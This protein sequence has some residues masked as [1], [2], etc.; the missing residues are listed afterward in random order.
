MLL[1][2]LPYKL[3]RLHWTHAQ[4]SP[5]V[6]VVVVVVVAMCVDV[7]WVQDLTDT[8]QRISSERVFVWLPQTAILCVPYNYYSSVLSTGT[9][10]ATCVKS[11]SGKRRQIVHT[12]VCVLEFSVIWIALFTVWFMLIPCLLLYFLS[13]KINDIHI[14]LRWHPCMKYASIHNN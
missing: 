4:E 14:V 1:N 12:Y 7:V 2:S 9:W 5:L 8:G 10:R 3:T 13:T 6:A 11:E